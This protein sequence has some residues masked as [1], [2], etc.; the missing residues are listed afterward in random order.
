MYVHIYKKRGIGSG[1]DVEMMSKTYTHNTE[2]IY[3]TQK[4]FGI[5]RE[6]DF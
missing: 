1:W 6:L 3:I 2:A 5:Q 4:L